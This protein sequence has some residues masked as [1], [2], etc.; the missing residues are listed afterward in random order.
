MHPTAP[1]APTSNPQPGPGRYGWD[2]G[3]EEVKAGLDAL[4]AERRRPNFG[5]AGAVNNLLAAVALRIEARVAGVAPE[6]RANAAPVPA[7]F[8]PDA[9]A[10]PPDPETL[11]DDLVGCEALRDRIKGWRATIRANQQRGRDPLDT[12]E[13]NFLF[14]G[15]PGRSEAR[16][17]E[18]LHF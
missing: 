18:G 6:G 12:F 17:G 1:T 8:D 4:K 5:N 16:A 9:G 3:L 2:L 14:T 11:L 15:S 13:L 7:D 10:P